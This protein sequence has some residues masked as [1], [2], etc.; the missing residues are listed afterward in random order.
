LKGR[1]QIGEMSEIIK[2][3]KHL[4]QTFNNNHGLT[5]LTPVQGSRDGFDEAAKNGGRW[6]MSGVFM[7]S[8]FDKSLNG[9]FYTFLDPEGGDSQS[10]IN[11]GM[12]KS[13]DSSI[14]GPVEVDIH[15]LSGEIGFVPPGGEGASEAAMTTQVAPDEMDNFFRWE[16]W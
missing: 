13:R 16:D 8:E 4:C 1:D 14:F 6:N 9:C 11:F 15:P 12:C 2:D 10:K 5:M 3:A 7:F